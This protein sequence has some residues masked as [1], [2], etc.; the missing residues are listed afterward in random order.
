MR[1]RSTELVGSGRPQTGIWWLLKKKPG[2]GPRLLGQMA[3]GETAISH[4]TFRTLPSDRA[5]DSSHTLPL[6]FRMP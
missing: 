5:H 3:R 4:V 1:R 2:T 6:T